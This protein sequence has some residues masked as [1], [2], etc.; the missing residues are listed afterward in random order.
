MNDKPS[1]RMKGR[2]AGPGLFVYGTLLDA[3]VRT[4]VL[5][6]PL[7]AAQLQPAALKHMRRVYIA[8][9]LYPMIVPRRGAA[10]DGLLLT[11]LTDED[12][13]RLDAFEGAD[14]GRERQNIWPLAEDASEGEPVLAWL[15]RTRGVGPRPSPREWR[16]E[17]WRKREK[18][19]FLRAAKEWIVELSA[20]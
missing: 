12:Y 20:R 17:E 10:V 14:Y 16:L 11:A 19:V 18:P 15:Y 9:R 4:L 8:G 6:R 13:A 2:A 3:D 1:P 5:G 7:D